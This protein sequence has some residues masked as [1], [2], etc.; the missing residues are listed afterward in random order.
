MENSPSVLNVVI[1]VIRWIARILAAF[2]ILLTLVFFLGEEVFDNSPGTGE[3]IPILGIITG[4]LML[5]GLGM[6]FKWELIGGIISLIGFIGII[7]VNNDAATKPM[8]F[9][10]ALPAVLFVLCGLR[11]GTRDEG[12]ETSEE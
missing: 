8:F 3:P 4:I 7:L 6:A 2:M 12:Q 5:G 10:Y 11:K 1:N 9:L